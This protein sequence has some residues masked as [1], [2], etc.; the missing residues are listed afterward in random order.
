MNPDHGLGRSLFSALAAI[1]VES[2]HPELAQSKLILLGFSGIGA[3]FAHFLAYAPDRI[4][5]AILAN[6]GQTEPENVDN[7]VLSARGTAVPV[8]IVVG[9]RVRSRVPRSRMRSSNA[10]T[11]KEP[12]GFFSFRMASHTAA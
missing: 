11:R 6:P 9:S 3:Y 10:T 4:L 1:G 5:A 2:G 7:V 8:L 12:L